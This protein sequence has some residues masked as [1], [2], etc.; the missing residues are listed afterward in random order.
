MPRLTF[1]ERVDAAMRLAQAAAWPFTPSRAQ[2][3]SALRPLILD[4]QDMPVHEAREY[5]RATHRG[6]GTHDALAVS[7]Y[8]DAPHMQ[9]VG[10]GLDRH[11]IVADEWKKFVAAGAALATRRNLKLG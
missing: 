1:A 9:R 6:A 7:M 5:I 3:E 10:F 11:G 8:K 2:E 4:L